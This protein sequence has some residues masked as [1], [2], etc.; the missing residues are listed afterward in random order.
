MLFIAPA[1]ALLPFVAIYL[2]LSST[3]GEL[4]NPFTPG[5]LSIWPNWLSLGFSSPSPVATASPFIPVALVAPTGLVEVTVAPTPTPTP[6]SQA[7]THSPS[8]SP[9]AVHGTV[10]S[11]QRIH[12]VIPWVVHAQ[13]SAY[14]AQLALASEMLANLMEEKYRAIG[15]PHQPSPSSSSPSSLSAPAR[16]IDASPSPSPTRTEPLPVAPSS[17]QTSLTDVKRLTPLRFITPREFQAYPSS[18]Q[19]KSAAP[20][21]MSRFQHM[22]VKGCFFEDPR[23]C[24]RSSILD[25]FLDSFVGPAGVILV[26][27][28]ALVCAIGTSIGNTPYSS[29]SIGIPP[30]IPHSQAAITGCLASEQALDA[31]NSEQDHVSIPSN[32]RVTYRDVAVQTEDSLPGT[33]TMPAVMERA[34]FSA[35]GDASHAGLDEAFTL[36]DEIPMAP[37]AIVITPSNSTRDF[38]MAL[39]AALNDLR[40]LREYRDYSLLSPLSLSPQSTAPPSPVPSDYPSFSIPHWTENQIYNPEFLRRHGLGPDGLQPTMSQ[41]S[42][43]ESLHGLFEDGDTDAVLPMALTPLAAQSLPI[44]RFGDD[45]LTSF[46]FGFSMDGREGEPYVHK[47]NISMEGLAEPSGFEFVFLPPFKRCRRESEDGGASFIAPDFA[48]VEDDTADSTQDDGQIS[49]QITDVLDDVLA[50]P[51]PEPIPADESELVA[52][53]VIIVDSPPSTPT[54]SHAEDFDQTGMDDDIPM[55]S[56]PVKS[57]PSLDTF[58]QLCLASIRSNSSDLRTSSSLDGRRDLT[59]IPNASSS[60]DLARHLPPLTASENSEYLRATSASVGSA[61]S[62]QEGHVQCPASSLRE[63]S[64][65]RP[66]E[67]ISSASSDEPSGRIPPTWSF[68]TGAYLPPP[69]PVSTED[70]FFIGSCRSSSS[71]SSNIEPVPPV[72]ESVSDGIDS[73]AVEEN[74]GESV[75]ESLQP[76][77]S[78]SIPDTTQP[79]LLDQ[80]F[81]DELAGCDEYGFESA[82]ESGRASPSQSPGN[83]FDGMD[84][85]GDAMPCTLQ[86]AQSVEVPQEELSSASINLACDDGSLLVDQTSTKKSAHFGSASLDIC[87]TSSTD[88]QPPLNPTVEDCASPSKKYFATPIPPVAIFGDV[89]SFST[90]RDLPIPPMTWPP[91]FVLPPWKGDKVSGTDS[92]HPLPGGLV[93]EEVAPSTPLAGKVCHIRTS[94]VQADRCMPGSSDFGTP[95]LTFDTSSVASPASVFSTP[96]S[97]AYAR[98]FERMQAA[99]CPSR[100]VATPSPLRD[101]S[102][103]A[104][105]TPSRIPISSARIPKRAAGMT[106]SVGHRIGRETQGRTRHTVK[107]SSLA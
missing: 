65:H 23:A 37:P 105:S 72:S 81:E 22:Q 1:L 55:S 95:E 71:S 64:H 61:S 21:R 74:G 45:G 83:D 28:A 104:Y 41:R 63:V 86:P 15:L 101:C 102:N 92:V 98:S 91:P 77:S 16:R 33:P 32:L 75:E 99:L 13:S 3:I 2:S 78:F 96:A 87:D 57:R 46:V 24:P 69:P 44:Q 53:P 67:S 36:A 50:H 27:V 17:P 10:V 76:D 5:A 51:P 93:K 103:T 85:R 88:V 26:F 68:D 70:S 34:D 97:L 79:S 42:S 48:G 7:A 66:L 59:G 107:F 20:T 80:T 73:V 29:E 31:S 84:E 56:T 25:E 35:V 100:G 39:E 40:H 89:P 19:V 54:Q 58:R 4:H 11:H 47:A 38:S 52:M 8:T 18:K 90:P 94:K 43:F 30:I 12:D 106:P 49:M 82:D 9:A 6:P 14:H 62:E 60:D